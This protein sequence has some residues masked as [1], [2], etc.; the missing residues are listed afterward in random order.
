MAVFCKMAA[1]PSSKT[2]ENGF[3]VENGFKHP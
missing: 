1:F 2:Q 3:F